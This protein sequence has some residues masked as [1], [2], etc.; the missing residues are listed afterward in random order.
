M[1]FQNKRIYRNNP[2][3]PGQQIQSEAIMQ[4]TN[5]SSKI[6]TKSYSVAQG[7]RIYKFNM[8]LRYEKAHI[9]I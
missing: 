1:N 6:S 2:N 4:K 8:Y 3:V 5:L 9:I 7:I